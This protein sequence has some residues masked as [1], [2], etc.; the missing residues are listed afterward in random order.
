MTILPREVGDKEGG[1]ENQSNCVVKPLVVAEGV[2]ATLVGNDPDTREDAALE[3]PVD[4]PG[5]V[6]E[7]AG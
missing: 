2:M 3:G 7:R 5:E 4:G 6:G 1:V